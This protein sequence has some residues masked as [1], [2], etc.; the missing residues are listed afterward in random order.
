MEAIMDTIVDSLFCFFVTL[1]EYHYILSEQ[2]SGSHNAHWSPATCSLFWKG[3][4]RNWNYAIKLHIHLIL[5]IKRKY[6][7][8]TDCSFFF[9]LAD[10]RSLKSQMFQ[11]WFWL[12]LTFFKVAKSAKHKWLLSSVQ[13]WPGGSVSQF[14]SQHFIQIVADFQ[15]CVVV[16]MT[17]GLALAL[18]FV[19]L[20]QSALLFHLNWNM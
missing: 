6:K 2:E 9:F 5:Q 13:T 20:D 16:D 11:I 19:R 4:V 1:G 12:I 7:D 15:T 18:T 10:Q 14:L 3:H 17:A 8:C